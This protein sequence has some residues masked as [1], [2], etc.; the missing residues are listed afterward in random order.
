[1][2]INQYKELSEEEVRLL[3]YILKDVYVSGLGTEM[4]DVEM[5]SMIMQIKSGSFEEK[6]ERV[7]NALSKILTIPVITEGKKYVLFDTFVSDG[8]RIFVYPKD[9][10]KEEVVAA[11]EYYASYILNPNRKAFIVT[12]CNIV[13]E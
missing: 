5:A 11:M 6:H 1:M 2:E 9:R 10:T 8:K 7:F 12:G 4:I 13:E 3:K